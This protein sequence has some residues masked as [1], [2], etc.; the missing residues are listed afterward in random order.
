MDEATRPGSAVVFPGMSPCRFADFGKFLLINPFL[1]DVW[2]GRSQYEF[3]G[4]QVWVISKEGLLKMKREAGR[5]IDLSDIE[6]LP[7]ENEP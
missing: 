2:K 5:P 4:R 6:N 7:K 1:E 3:W